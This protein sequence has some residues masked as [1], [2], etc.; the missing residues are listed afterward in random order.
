MDWYQVLEFA[1]GPFFLLAAI[2]FISG[3]CYRL[4]RMLLQGWRQAPTA[5]QGSPASGIWRSFVNGLFI[6]PFLPG[7]KDS[8]LLNPVT[9]LAGGMFHLSLFVVLFLVT[10]HMLVWKSLIGVGWPTPPTPIVDWLAAAGI[11]AM[12]ALLINRMINP[13]LKWISGPAEYL[14]W[15]FVF[16]PMVTGYMMTHH[17]WFRYEILFSVHM[18]SVDVMLIWIPF[19]RL[20]HFMYYFF[21]R[22]IRGI[23]F[24]PQGVERSS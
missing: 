4:A 6:F 15:L 20:S 22:A 21:S 7:V 3:M 11:V 23:Q 12:L 18:L 8:F 19:S 1:R 14:N 24:N 5:R 2:I 16:L 13:V 10:A 9:Y 17:L